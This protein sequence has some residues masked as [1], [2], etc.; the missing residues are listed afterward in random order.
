[1]EST[2]LMKITKLIKINISTYVICIL[3]IFSGYK[4][5]LI[6]LLLPLLVH[7][8]G[9]I[10]FIKI[11]KEKLTKIEI[12]P[13]GGLIEINKK[14]NYPV[15]KD[16]FISS[17]G[18]IFQF[19]LHIVNKVTIN[20][21]YINKFNLI[22]LF[23]N[24][25]PIIPL[26][27]S[28]IILILISKFISYLKAIYIY[29][30]VSIISLIGFIIFSIN[31]NCLNIFIIIYCIFFLLKE[32]M[33]ILSKMNRFYIERL[34]YDLNFKKCKYYRKCNVKY[35]KQETEGFFF[36]GVWKNERE[37]L[38]KKFDINTYF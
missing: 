19:I 38:A 8:I 25:L 18:I 14:I 35:L 22:I 26:D 21:T 10:Y 32:N 2:I 28:K 3:L 5:Y 6:Y 34:V 16:L 9:H 31:H 1:M 36:D 30:F 4:R 15:I 37:I 33:E 29:I 23:L 7:E 11:F 20:N 17:G 12:F 27:G 24:T 13:F